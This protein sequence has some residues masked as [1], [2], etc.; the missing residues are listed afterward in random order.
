LVG[1][2]SELYHT[3]ARRPEDPEDGAAMM[4]LTAR[5]LEGYPGD[6]ALGAI[7]NWRGIYFPVAEELRRRIE[8]MPAFRDRA[9]KIRALREFLDGGPSGAPRD[10]PAAERARVSEGFRKLRAEIDARGSRFSVGADSGSGADDG[11]P[12]K[13]RRQRPGKSLGGVS[14]V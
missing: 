8:A 5:A 3:T 11:A 10:I 1:A 2:L 4:V 13:T 14:D 12:I 7:K 9:A 6:I